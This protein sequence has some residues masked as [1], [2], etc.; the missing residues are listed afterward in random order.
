MGDISISG[1]T[2]ARRMKLG[3]IIELA[4]T[5]SHAKALIN[6]CLISGLMLINVN[7]KCQNFSPPDSS[8]RASATQTQRREKFDSSLESSA[9]RF[10][11]GLSNF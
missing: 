2:E 9:V 1:T 10:L 3:T 7:F 11:S 6:P 5:T 8:A 4:Y